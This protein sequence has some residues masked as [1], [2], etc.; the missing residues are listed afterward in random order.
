MLRLMSIKKAPSLVKG[1]SLKEVEKMLHH[2]A[3]LFQE[4]KLVVVYYLMFSVQV[5]PVLCYI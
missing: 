1:A 3:D 2:E 5:F 4:V